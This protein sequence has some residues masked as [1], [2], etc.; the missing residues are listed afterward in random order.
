MKKL[1]NVNGIDFES[2][3][4]AKAHRDSLNGGA[5]KLG[6]PHTV[7]RGSDHRLGRS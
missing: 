4:E 3:Q 7:K 6:M 5:Y 2:K 1:F